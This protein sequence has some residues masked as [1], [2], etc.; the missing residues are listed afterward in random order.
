[1]KTIRQIPILL[2]DDVTYGAYLEATPEQRADWNRRWLARVR[3]SDLDI[4]FDRDR[5]LDER[6]LSASQAYRDEHPTQ[7][8]GS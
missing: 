4:Q 6:G 1:M 8:G 7:S 3:A 2:P 5:D